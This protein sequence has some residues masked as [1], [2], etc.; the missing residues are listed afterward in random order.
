MPSLSAKRKASVEELAL[1]HC[2]GLPKPYLAAEDED[3]RDPP[4][5]RTMDELLV[6]K[7][8]TNEKTL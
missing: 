1:Q 3:S 7:D 2:V 6:S 4:G 5:K 8:F